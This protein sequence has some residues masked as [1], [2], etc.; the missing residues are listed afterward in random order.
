M[1]WFINCQEFPLN[2][3]FLRCILNV[4][5][6]TCRLQDTYLIL[7]T[8]LLQ[9]RYGSRWGRIG[10][11]SSSGERAVIHYIRGTCCKAFCLL[12]GSNGILWKQRHSRGNTDVPLHVHTPTLTCSNLRSQIIGQDQQARLSSRTAGSPALLGKVA[13]RFWRRRQ[14]LEP[15]G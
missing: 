4:F 6:S 1:L 14:L 10:Q 11:V 15:V 7:K 12:L 5:L 8:I 2:A 13:Q 3:D 9:T